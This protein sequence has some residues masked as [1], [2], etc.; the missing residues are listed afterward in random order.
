MRRFLFLA[1]I[2]F[3]GACVGT[4]ETNDS[5]KKAVIYYDPNEVPWG[6]LKSLLFKVES[7]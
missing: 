4:G 3:L 6:I 1:G 2:L 5:L 7:S